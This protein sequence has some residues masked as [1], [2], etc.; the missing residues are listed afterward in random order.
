MLL[1]AGPGSGESSGTCESMG[2]KGKGLTGKGAS[3]APFLKEHRRVSSGNMFG[4]VSVFSAQG[5]RGT[6][7][8]ARF[9]PRAVRSGRARRG[10]SDKRSMGAAVHVRRIHNRH[11]VQALRTGEAPT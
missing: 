11:A 2:A 10:L 1:V 6:H 4:R 9:T 7:A 8:C 5:H 3:E